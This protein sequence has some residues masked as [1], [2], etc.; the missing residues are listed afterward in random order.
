[1]NETMTLAETIAYTAYGK[2]SN[3]QWKALVHMADVETRNANRVANGENPWRIS[4]NGRETTVKALV[5][6][7]LI[8]ATSLPD[9]TYGATHTL[10]VSQAGW[11]VLAVGNIDR[12]A[13]PGR[14][15]LEEAWDDAHRRVSQEPGLADMHRVSARRVEAESRITLRS[16][17]HGQFQVSAESLDRLMDRYLPASPRQ[18][19]K[20]I[21]ERADGSGI[22]YSDLTTITECLMV[23]GEYD[24]FATN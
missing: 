17:E 20:L 16:S 23:L 21:E 24:G 10:S 6:R 14:M 22:D 3:A 13:D 4:W 18:L 7:G 12:P 9:A 1:M 19:R 8:I 2:L 15:S 5:K 11:N